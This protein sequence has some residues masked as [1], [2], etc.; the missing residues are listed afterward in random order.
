L[1]QIQL[2]ILLIDLDDLDA[3][4]ENLSEGLE[5]V[6]ASL[7]DRHPAAALALK[8]LAYI[9]LQRD[10]YD[11]AARLAADAIAIYRTCGPERLGELR[12]ACGFRAD[13]L[14]LAGQTAEAIGAYRDLMDAHRRP[15]AAEK[16]ALATDL[17]H[18]GSL[19]HTEERD[20]EA[21]RTLRECR[22]ICDEAIPDDDPR[23]H[24]KF[25]AMG[26]LGEI[27]TGRAAKLLDQTRAGTPETPPAAGP[28]T[29][30][31][32][33]LDAE[34]LLVAAQAGVWSNPTTAADPAR[35]RT[36]LARLVTL[37]E[38]MDA[39]MRD[40]GYADKAAE[41]RARLDAEIAT[42]P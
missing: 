30:I 36:A 23:A 4:I 8:E 41:W 9:D 12:A 29:P 11:D 39:A 15:P 10:S 14:R 22:A 33:L 2:G 7:G 13:A 18:L 19:L 20:D 27:L 17:L 5:S 42:D 37:Y 21:E 32:R 31:D 38:A 25:D 24:I 1:F 16:S 35:R 40:N 34:P 28:S 6:R 26:L 3:A